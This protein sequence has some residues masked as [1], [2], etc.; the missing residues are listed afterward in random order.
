MFGALFAKYEGHVKLLF[1]QS[2]YKHLSFKWF[3]LLCLKISSVRRCMVHILIEYLVT[4][5]LTRSIK[6]FFLKPIVQFI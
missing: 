4:I 5:T 3:I 2:L 1:V 6:F